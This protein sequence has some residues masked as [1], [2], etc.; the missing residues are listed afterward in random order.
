VKGAL[1]RLVVAGTL[2]AVS[3]GARAAGTL[4]SLDWEAPA[5]CPDAAEIAHRVAVLLD[6][7]ADTVVEAQVRVTK[8]TTG[9]RTVVR[10]RTPR[11]QGERVLDTA[12]C[13]AAGEASALVI[14][15]SAAPGAQFPAGRADGSPPPPPAAA[16]STAPAASSAPAAAAT[17][18]PPSAP[19][20]ASAPAPGGSALAT[21]AE[22]GTPAEAIAPPSPVATDR[23]QG[24]ASPEVARGAL[25][26]HRFHVGAGAV[27]DTASLPQ[28]AVGPT[29]TVSARLLE[30]LSVDLSGTYWP[31]QTAMLTSTIGGHFDLFDASLRGCYERQLVMTL[32]VCAG[33]F[34]DWLRGNG[35]GTSL[36][37]AQS[38][39][40]SLYGGP[41]AAGSAR[42]AFTDW[43]GARVLAEA[44]V[45]LKRQE[46]VVLGL[47]GFVHRPAAVTARLALSLE[48]TF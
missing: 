39:Q 36:S 25:R 31:T 10:V 27:A 30:G 29:V 9:Y 20:I 45:P 13:A 19:P 17:A 5:G 37:Q 14:A 23:P 34:L 1:R 15:M 22:S 47:D 33:F 7:R 8:E 3:G 28:P 12:S 38:Q 16:A 11:G 4:P 2:I 6:G 48:A 18:P 41:L 21:P 46:F 44:D 35:F 43:L 26:P 32:G 24:P 40:T 42:Y